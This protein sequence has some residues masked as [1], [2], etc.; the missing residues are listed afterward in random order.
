M[1][2]PTS[3]LRLSLA[4][5]VTC[6]ALVAL[7]ACTSDPFRPINPNLSVQPPDRS[8]NGFDTDC[9]ELTPE[10]IHLLCDNGGVAADGRIIDEYGRYCTCSY[11]DKF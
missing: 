5:A 10:V 11:G 2:F 9:L 1:T 4:R 6:V 8:P 3:S 7:T